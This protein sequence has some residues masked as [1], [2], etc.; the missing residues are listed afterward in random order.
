[1]R[2]ALWIWVW[3]DQ[4]T[5]ISPKARTPKRGYARWASGQVDALSVIL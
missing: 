4:G 1:M 2:P 3:M 5:E